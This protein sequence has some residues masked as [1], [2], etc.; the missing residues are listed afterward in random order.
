[1]SVLGGEQPLQSEALRRQ[2][3]PSREF[4]LSDP[5]GTSQSLRFIDQTDESSALPQNEVPEGIRSKSHNKVS[6]DVFDLS[7]RLRRPRIKGF[8]GFVLKILAVVIM[9]AVFSGL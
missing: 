1:M 8:C 7:H 3:L 6:L 4:L 2:A 5:P 9:S